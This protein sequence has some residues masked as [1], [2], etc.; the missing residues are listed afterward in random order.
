MDLD[1]L[2]ALH[3]L[4]DGTAIDAAASAVHFV[5]ENRCDRTGFVGR[6]QA[7]AKKPSLAAGLRG[8]HQRF[9]DEVQEACRIEGAEEATAAADSPCSDD[10]SWCR[11]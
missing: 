2:K 4:E 3:P 5:D 8:S 6:L 7:G 9:R 1:F 11:G 10:K